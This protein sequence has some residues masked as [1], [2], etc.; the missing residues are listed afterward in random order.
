MLISRA[1]KVLI[2]LRNRYPGARF[3]SESYSYIF[4]FDQS[5]LDEWNW[6]EHF[7]GQEE[8][9][10]YCQFFAKKFKLHDD[11]Q[12]NTR[13]SSA[14]WREDS[15]SWLVKDDFPLPDG[16][17][18]RSS[19]P[20]AFASEPERR[21]ALRL[22]YPSVGS[23]PDLSLDFKSTLAIRPIIA[24]SRTQYTNISP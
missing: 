21:T 1:S 13:V 17:H 5:L 3:D 15:N 18:A 8:T 7:A 11:M 20:L 14:H 4:S 16:H 19:S 12:F 9:L 23:G 2:T 6:T 10:S 22:L 24:Q